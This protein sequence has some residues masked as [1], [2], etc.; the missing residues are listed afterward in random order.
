MKEIDKIYDFAIIGDGITAGIMR[1]IAE[2]TKSEYVCFSNGQTIYNRKDPRSLALSTSTIKTFNT[3]GIELKAQKVKKMSIYE[4]GLGSIREK[5]KLVFDMKDNNGDHLS[6]IVKY[7]EIL[8]ILGKNVRN[9]HVRKISDILSIKKDNKKIFINM[10]NGEVIS[11]KLLIFTNKLENKFQKILK[12]TYR[13]KQYDQHAIVA[14][15]LHEKS[16]EGEASQFFIKGGPF[17]LLP[18]LSEKKKNLSSLIWTN[19]SSTANELIKSPRMIISRLNELCKNKLGLVEIIEGPKSFPLIKY[20]LS[21]NSDDRLIFAGDSIRSMH[22]LLGQAWN[23]AIRDLTYISDALMESRRLATEVISVPSF[24]A[25]KRIRL[26]EGLGMVNASDLINNIY[27]SDSS[28]LKGLRRNA[29]N[30]I[31]KVDPV[32]KLLINEASRGILKRPSLSKA[33]SVKIEND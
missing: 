28:L 8:E 1:S 5:S 24:R 18:L 31:N 30:I 21:G 25:Y 2:S 3:L 33:F 16:H 20:I 17:A 13:E 32:K 10:S 19:P 29:M 4:G 6:Y 15:L 23:Q 27:E 11:S 9:G 26:I 12:L 7:D 14:T 22:P